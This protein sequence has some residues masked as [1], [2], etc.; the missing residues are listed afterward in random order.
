MVILIE[1]GYEKC[2][3]NIIQKLFYIG[4]YYYDTSGTGKKWLY[5]YL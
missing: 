2:Y 3:N 5:L 1:K 4:G